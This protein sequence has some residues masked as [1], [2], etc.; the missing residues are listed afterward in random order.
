MRAKSASRLRSR[1][2]CGLP[3]RRVFE[4]F[5]ISIG[6]RERVIA[7]QRQWP[8]GSHERLSQREGIRAIQ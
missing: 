2:F 7:L 3:S 5:T 8:S 1:Q 6:V 4:V